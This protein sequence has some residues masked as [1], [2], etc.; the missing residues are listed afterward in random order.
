[1]KVVLIPVEHV[2]GS[3]NPWSARPV[4]RI[5]TF[6]EH[7]MTEEVVSSF[8]R[9]ATAHK[10]ETVFDPFV[11][12]GTVLVEARKCGF[13]CIGQDANPWSII[14][15]SAKT[16]RPRISEDEMLDLIDGINDCNSLV[17]TSTLRRYHTPGQIDK[18]GRLRWVVE[19]G[20]RSDKDLGLTILGKTCVQYSRMRKSPAPRFSHMRAKNSTSRI[21]TAFASHFLQALDDLDGTIDGHD[22]RLMIGDSSRSAPDDVD[23][24]LTSPPFAN[25]IDYIRHT[26][27]ELFWSG[28]ARDSNGNGLLR[29][30]QIPACEAAARQWKQGTTR[31]WILDRISNVESSRNYAT[32][33][34]QYFRAMEDHFVVVKDALTWEAWYTIGDSYF[35]GVHIP[36]SQMLAKLARE[37]GFTTSIV[38]LGH[39]AGGRRLDVLRLK[40]S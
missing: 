5:L 7:G 21:P 25:N 12:S 23:G 1:M 20:L 9:K 18:L 13:R 6:S 8:L 31:K 30:S 39:R 2:Q 27:L 19:N 29:S 22:V 14:V 40:A 24:I 37:C 28:L 35:A 26:Q 11:G 4:H 15:T 3:R 34:S 32:F 10:C 36:T 16:R 17:P 38:P 33:L